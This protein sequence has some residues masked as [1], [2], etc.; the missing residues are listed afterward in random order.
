MR[1]SSGAAIARGPHRETRAGSIGGGPQRSQE[2]HVPAARVPREGTRNASTTR[3]ARRSA[4]PRVVRRR[5]VVRA[6][7]PDGHRRGA[8]RRDG[9]ARGPTRPDRGARSR[10]QRCARQGA[11]RVARDRGVQRRGVQR[12]DDRA[13][14]DVDGGRPDVPPGADGPVH[15][16]VHPGRLDLRQPAQDLRARPAARG[17][18]LGG[19]QVFTRARELHG[20]ARALLRLRSVTRED[21]VTAGASRVGLACPEQDPG[22]RTGLRSPRCCPRS[23]ATRSTRRPPIRSLSRST[24]QR[25][26]P[27]RS[28]A[29][30]PS[31]HRDL[32]SSAGKSP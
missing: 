30:A 18:R 16:R 29:S 31:R 25:L 5:D 7:A 26:P 32:T 24:V 8:A 3:C 9:V 4:V 28:T 10:D 23:P 1:P 22:V 11:A 6:V 17:R 2:R 12:G 15:Q 19:K 27:R 14:R 13:V 20:G 21:L